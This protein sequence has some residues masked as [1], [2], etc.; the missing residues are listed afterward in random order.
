MNVVK[1]N[2]RIVSSPR[3]QPIKYKL[4]KVLEVILI[5]SCSD[6]SLSTWIMSTHM[7]S[8]IDYT[9]FAVILSLKIPYIL[10]SDIKM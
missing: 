9:N 3:A 5:F 4:S 7:T 2:E 8:K 10:I 6:F 1:R